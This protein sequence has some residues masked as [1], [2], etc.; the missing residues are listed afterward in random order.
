MYRLWPF[1]RT[2]IDNVQMG[3]AKTDMA[4]ASLYAELT[5]E[6]TRQAIFDDFFEE[7]QRTERL[8]LQVANAPQLLDNEPVLRRSITVR[9]PYV[10]PMN[11]MQVGLIRRLRTETDPD[12]RR[13]LQ[14]A[15]LLSVNGIAAGLQN[16][17]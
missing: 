13:K 6:A 9:N 10:D 11:Y 5:D 17:G 2:V 8:V 14:Q 12:V 16:T 15:I 1:F 7:E 3:L 4:V